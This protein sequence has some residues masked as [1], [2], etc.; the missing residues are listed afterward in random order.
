[1]ISD[2]EIKQVNANGR[3]DLVVKGNA[4][5]STRFQIAAPPLEPITSC[6]TDNNELIADLP[7]NFDISSLNE[8][9]MRKW[10]THKMGLFL[11]ELHNNHI[12]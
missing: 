12:I 8:K 2:D 1:M 4:E 10:A 5:S 3:E 9:D 7:S 11:C 6:Y